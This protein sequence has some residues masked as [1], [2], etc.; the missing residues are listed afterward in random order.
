MNE[1]KVTISELAELAQ[2]DTYKELT[3]PEATRE[4]ARLLEVLSYKPS[5]A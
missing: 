3:V 5:H 4:I 2:V 1:T